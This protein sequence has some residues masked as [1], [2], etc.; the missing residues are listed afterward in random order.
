MRADAL[1]ASP[2]RRL[3]PLAVAAEKRGTKVLYLNIGQPDVASP[4]PFWEGIRAAASK[5]LEYC[6]SPGV[7][8]LREV[9]VD[10][11]NKRGFPVAPEDMLVTTGG[12]E[13]TLMAFMCCFNPGDEVIV[14]E[15]YYANY[16]SFA[17][18]SGV[19][20]VA[21]T[22]KLEDD[23][24]LPS[25]EEIAAKVTPKTRGILVCNPSNP[26]G[27]IFD[28]DDMHALGQLALKHDLFL[29][30]DEVYRD[31]NYTDS[32]LVSVLNLPG[33]EQNA[34]ML[35][36][37]SKR[38]SLCGARIGFIVSKNKGVMDGANKMAQA[39]LSAPTLDQQGV[40]QA[41]LH[42]PQEYFA[43]VRAEYMRRRDT[44]LRELRAIPGVVAPN[45]T[46]A[47]YAIARLPVPDAEEFCKWML[48]EFSHEG[49]TVLFA[50]GAG[51]YL[52]PG[53][54]MDEIRIAY[55]VE[56]AKLIRAANCLRAALAAYPKVLARV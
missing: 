6:P 49:E 35:D 12:S 5:T 36:S 8:R 29:I 3:V 18:S 13:A 14:I 37:V 31:F 39:R 1:P 24:R 51:F 32:R 42:T 47:F 43:E 30:G 38:F 10:D 9:A 16:S 21:L 7:T 41:I 54:G 44:L 19:K 25:V 22:S 11:Y 2:I 45:I 52:T 34:V 56:E 33:L 23:F 26:T 46:G 55:V 4:E 48:E 28:A 40:I 15:P 53:L 27:S 20:L 17:V 50:P